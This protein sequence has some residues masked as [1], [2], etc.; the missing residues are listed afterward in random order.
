[1]LKEILKI[2]VAT[3]IIIV[4]I[5]I[6]HA[7]TLDRIIQYK[8]ISFSSSNIPPAMNGY[9]IAFVS[10]THFLSE[11]DLWEVVAE[12][13]QRQ[14]DLLI[15]GGDLILAEDIMR[16]KVQILAQVETVDGIFGVEGNHD[17]YVHLFAAM[18][19]NGIIPL[20]NS[21][22][23]IRDRFYLAGVADPSNRHSCVASA[24]AGSTSDDFVLLISHQ[25]DVAMEQNTVGIDLILSGHTH[26][27][28]INF[29]GI[30]APY[31]TLRDNV[32][33]YGQRF[34]SGW[35]LSRDGVPVFVSNGVGEYLPRV[36]ARPQVIL[37]TLY[38]E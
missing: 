32:T 19:E 30:W 8:E 36:F 34:R 28:Q 17:Y 25:P 22:Q 7:L 35:A 15:L 27:G 21:G 37:L 6:I 29:F 31:F 10:D 1:M 13:N 33:S 5:H 23:Y 24:I 2:V 14:V 11:D 20:S 9:R 26:G 12:I 16:R 4:L 3:G 38:Y 18:E